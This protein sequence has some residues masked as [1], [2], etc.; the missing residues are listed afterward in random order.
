MR[1]ANLVMFG[2]AFVCA[3]SAAFLMRGV[4]SRSE[5]PAVTVV[6]PAA[7]TTVVVAVRDIRPGEKLGAD[8]VREAA[9]PQDSVPKGAFASKE[10]L[11]KTGGERQIAVALTENEP[12][13]QTKLFGFSDSL[14]RPSD[15]MT[16]FTIRVS[17]LAAGGGFVQP[18]DKVDV[19]MTQADRIG[20]EG[21]ASKAYVV[22]LLRNVKVLAV[23][24]QTQRKVQGT[25]PKSVTLEVTSQDAKRLILASTIGQLSLTLNPGGAWNSVDSGIV[26]INELLRLQPAKTV[27]APPID[28]D[29]VV[30]VTRSIERKDYKVPEEARR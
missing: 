13:L 15:G 1:P 2:I 26:D 27:E 9:W 5:Q 19:F 6:S 11:F 14:G 23:D 20:G 7:T 30:T 10:A 18:E 16:S 24:Q 3:V 25:P 22:T 12:V 8:A 29:P 17:E 21:M 4:L 28:I